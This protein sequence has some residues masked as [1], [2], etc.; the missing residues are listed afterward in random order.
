MNIGV[1]D[2]NPAILNYLET[3]LSMD[4]HRV[5]R[6]ATGASLLEALS[7]AP[8]RTIAQRSGYPPYDLIILDLLL[9]GTQSGAD[10]FMSIR[11]SFPVDILPIIVI[12]AVSEPTLE[13]FRHILPDDV[14]LLRKPFPPRALR[15]LIADIF[16]YQQL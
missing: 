7:S 15:K 5:F 3:T 16:P 11:K 2:D 12:T 13:Q 9:P 6:Y 10:V 4:G 1:L 14:P 8:S